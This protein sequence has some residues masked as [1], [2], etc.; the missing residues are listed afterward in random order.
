MK[1]LKDFLSKL[2]TSRPV[3]LLKNLVLIFCAGFTA[4]SQVS[5]S[6]FMPTAYG[7]VSAKVDWLHSFLSPLVFAIAAIVLMI[8]CCLLVGYELHSDGKPRNWIAAPSVLAIGAAAIAVLSLISLQGERTQRPRKELV[9]IG[10]DTARVVDRGEADAQA[11]PIDSKTVPAEE[12]ETST[13]PVAFE[14]GSSPSRPLK[15]GG[16]SESSCTC[17]TGG[18]ATTPPRI[19]EKSSSRSVERETRSEE[20]VDEET[21]SESS[22][23]SSTATQVQAEAAAAAAQARAEA[24]ATSAQARAEAAQAAAQA[25]SE[26]MAE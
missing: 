5:G 21:S 16:G 20:F 6:T 1:A 19:E 15:R 11:S 24:A 10:V 8:V 25:Q 2:H 23:E 22:S 17:G 26:A 9:V 13:S 7:F 4:L 3:R 18:S 14:S 12:A